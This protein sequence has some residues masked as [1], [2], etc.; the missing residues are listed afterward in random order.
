MTVVAELGKDA[1]LDAIKHATDGIFSLMLSMEVSP[2]EPS[3]HSDPAP[4]DGVVAL[5]SFTGDWIGTGMLYCDERLACKI[6]SAMM[7]TEVKEVT[8]DV[9]DGIGE[10][11]NMILG[12]FKEALEGQTGPLQLSVPMVVWGKNFQT[13]SGIRAFWTVVPF[14]V[15]GGIFEVRVCMKPK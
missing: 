3:E 11:A 6:G 4:I 5:L 10:M 2:E 12:S 14:R 8:S 13:R 1:I 15:A 7:M 9:L